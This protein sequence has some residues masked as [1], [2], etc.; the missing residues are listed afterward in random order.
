M[1]EPVADRWTNGL[2]RV[3]T[4]KDCATSWSGGKNGK[5]FRCSLC[6][7]KFAVGDVWRW[8]YANDGS[9]PGG[10]FMVCQSCDGPD[11]KERRADWMR[12]FGWMFHE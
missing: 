3:A 9:C 8:V 12:R 4:E 1:S 10:N 11:V 7:H 6:G 2:P 5:Y